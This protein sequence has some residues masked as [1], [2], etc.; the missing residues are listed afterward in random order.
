MYFVWENPQK[1]T[2]QLHRAKTQEQIKTE[3]NPVNGSTF[4]NVF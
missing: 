2:E 1:Y 3:R 4:S